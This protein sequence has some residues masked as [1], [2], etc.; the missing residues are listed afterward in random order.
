MVLGNNYSYFRDKVTRLKKDKNK[1]LLTI[2]H[3][4]NGR[5]PIQAEISFDLK[6]TFWSLALLWVPWFRPLEITRDGSE[7]L[8]TGWQG[9]YPCSII[10]HWQEAPDKDPF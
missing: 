6:L 9:W 8:S 5:Y 7:K 2:T 3:I 1:F 4:I 10:T